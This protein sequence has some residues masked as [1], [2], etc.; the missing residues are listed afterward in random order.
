MNLFSTFTVF[1]R[2]ELYESPE[3]LFFAFDRF[4]NKRRSTIRLISSNY[5][6]LNHKGQILEGY[7]ISK[8]NL[9]DTF[10]ITQNDPLRAQ[11][12]AV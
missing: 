10:K 2:I 3:N 12:P 4:Y 5:R 1:E 11:I 8:L 9:F 7:L 6:N